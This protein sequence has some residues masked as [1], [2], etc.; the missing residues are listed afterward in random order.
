MGEQVLYLR[1]NGWFWDFRT[2]GN[3][4]AVHESGE[5]WSSK[6]SPA[7]CGGKSGQNWPLW[8][9]SGKGIGGT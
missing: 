3:S 2:F 7:R 9:L 6:N 1:S 8:S 5:K 4:S